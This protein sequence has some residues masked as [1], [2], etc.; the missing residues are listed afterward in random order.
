MATSRF[1]RELGNLGPFKFSKPYFVSEIEVDS[2]SVLYQD[3]IDRS[4]S[5]ESLQD[6]KRI[7]DQ[8]REAQNE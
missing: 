7:L 8:L 2:L 1:T 5:A 4:I 6:A 3:L